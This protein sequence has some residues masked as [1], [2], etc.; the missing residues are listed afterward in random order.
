MNPWIEI[1]K[2]QAPLP[3]NIDLREGGG[4]RIFIPAFGKDNKGYFYLID[5][6]QRTITCWTIDNQK[7]KKEL[8][9]R[10][11]IDWSNPDAHYFLDNYLAAH[12]AQFYH[13][14]IYVTSLCSNFVIVL[15]LLDDGYDV[16]IND[17]QFDYVYSATNDIRDNSMYFTRWSLA[18]EVKIFLDVRST[19]TVEIGKVN[20]LTKEFTIFSS[21][22]SGNA[23]HQASL[24]PDCEKVVMLGMSTAAVG[25]FP[26]P[27]GSCKEADM[28]DL[29]EQG[30]LDSQ[31]SLYNIKTNQVSSMQFD[32][33][34]GH[35][36]YD[37][38]EDY[39]YI[40]NHNLGYDSLSKEMYCFGPGQINK[41]Y[42]DDS[43]HFLEIYGDVDFIRI[44]S[45]KVFTMG[46]ET[47]IAVSVYPNK[48]HVIRAK[49][50]TIYKKSTIFDS[51]VF[52]DFTKGPQ[53]YPKTD[54]TPYTIHPVDGTH[55]VHL[56]NVWNVR[57][58][59]FMSDAVIHTV[60]Y[61]FNRKDIIT[62]GHGL[63]F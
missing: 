50:M 47:Y 26:E 46:E 16:I 15:N 58:Y 44:P 62:M 41:I 9:K 37:V 3:E 36:E 12:S 49:D 4:K 35:I 43:I 19:I 52:T 34:T 53:P 45:H 24:T 10:M 31:I 28:H 54:R 48:V 29:L 11:N 22:I 32:S 21:F 59:D 18:D 56:A 38:K 5:Y 25:Q 30:L 60:N 17:E 20:L 6:P 42:I 2:E 39:C 63:D 7:I 27:D 8:Q 40:S 55:Y 23:I 33:G 57:L 61:N 13:D 1:T 14:K 51:K